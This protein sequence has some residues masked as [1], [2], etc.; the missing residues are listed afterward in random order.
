MHYLIVS[1]IAWLLV[2]FFVGRRFFQLWAAGLIGV[3]ITLVVDYF[4]TG[5]NLYIYPKGLFYIGSLP[6]FHFVQIY[7]LSILYFNWLPREWNAK[8]FYTA[9]VSAL[10]LSVEVLMHNLGAIVYPNWQLWYSYPLMIAGLSLMAYLAERL[11]LLK[12]T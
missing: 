3:I 10:F 7:A 8:L 6:L 5:H 9:Y 2:Y 12:N 1:A 11:R 4:G